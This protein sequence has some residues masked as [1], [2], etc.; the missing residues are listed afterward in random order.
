[1]DKAQET[2][3]PFS[4]PAIPP[5]FPAVEQV[6]E[7]LVL[8]AVSFNPPNLFASAS[9]KPPTG[10]MQIGTLISQMRQKRCEWLDFPMFLA[11]SG[12]G[13]GRLAVLSTPLDEATSATVQNDSRELVMA[14]GLSP[15]EPALW[16]TAHSPTLLCVP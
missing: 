10:D 12:G 7:F 13:S 4:S 3:S 9:F 6:Q 2:I 5:L 8:I 1:M 15:G 14:V 11:T 16:F